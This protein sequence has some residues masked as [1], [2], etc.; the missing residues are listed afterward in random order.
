[1]SLLGWGPKARVRS[2]RQQFDG[3]S[4]QDAWKTP[5][6]RK[7]LYAPAM[8]P[9]SLIARNCGS[10]KTF[11]ALAKTTIFGTSCALLVLKKDRWIGFP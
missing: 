7:C 1:M 10:S 2:A 3:G 11:D 8:D 4:H 9:V 6:H 5:L